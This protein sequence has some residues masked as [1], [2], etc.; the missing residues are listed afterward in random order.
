MQ[1]RILKI[2]PKDNVA[3]ALRDLAAGESLRIDDPWIV[4]LENIPAKPEFA[5][6]DFFPAENI[7]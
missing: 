6:S 7:R 4:L 3:V 1:Q 2:Y 5:L